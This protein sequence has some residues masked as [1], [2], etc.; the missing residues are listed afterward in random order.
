VKPTE[1]KTLTESQYLVNLWKRWHAPIHSSGEGDSLECLVGLG[2]TSD[3]QLLIE[4]E[5]F[6]G[7][8][9]R[10]ILKL[11]VNLPVRNSASMLVRLLKSKEQ[12][13]RLD[14]CG[15]Y[16]GVTLT[17]LWMQTGLDYSFVLLDQIEENP[18]KGVD[19]SLAVGYYAREGVFERVKEIALSDATGQDVRINLFLY[20]DH[21]FRNSE[22]MFGESL[23]VMRDLFQM[24][25]DPGYCEWMLNRFQDYSAIFFG[26]LPEFIEYVSSPD[27]GGAEGVLLA[28]AEVRF[29]WLKRNPSRLRD[30]GDMEFPLML[31]VP[32]KPFSEADFSR[33]YHLTAQ[34]P[35][36]SPYAAFNPLGG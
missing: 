1:P 4:A 22:R 10:V 13:P 2:I 19:A 32:P 11:L 5:N 20:F 21:M 34:I 3:E 31:A 28:T 24:K 17:A 16:L 18:A 6:Y 7:E 15:F 27:Y 36:P 8:R 33:G 9:L 26:V 30:E 25:W 23:R 12:I 29:N 35:I 14:E